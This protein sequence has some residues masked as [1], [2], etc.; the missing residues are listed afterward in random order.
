METYKIIALFVAVVMFSGCVAQQNNTVAQKGTENTTIQ[1]QTIDFSKRASDTLG[2]CSVISGSEVSILCQKPVKNTSLTPQA[3]EVCRLRFYTDDSELVLSYK[4]LP[5]EIY[6]TPKNALYG[7]FQENK[8]A[9]E[10]GSGNACIFN[11]YTTMNF[12]GIKYMII[13][14]NHKMCNETQM[15]YLASLLKSRIYG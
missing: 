1:N 10:A 4:K 7:C 13:V 5:T 3:D 2:D 12:V 9:K 11:N 8:D 6:P 14:S 15:L